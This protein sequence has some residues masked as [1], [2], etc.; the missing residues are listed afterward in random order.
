MSLTII[1]YFQDFL[2][3]ISSN[4]R[5]GEKYKTIVKKIT[6]YY[7]FFKNL[8]LCIQFF[9]LKKSCAFI[10]WGDFSHPTLTINSDVCIRKNIE[11]AL[12]KTISLE[13]IYYKKIS[14]NHD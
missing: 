1:N 10:S 7:F 6:I 4:E 14:W 9:F 2:C 8:I 3:L 11:Y 13:I 5:N 12:P